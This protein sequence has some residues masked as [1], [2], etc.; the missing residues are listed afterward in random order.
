[1]DPE[2]VDDLLLIEPER[3]ADTGRS[4]HRAEDRGRMEAGF[5]HRFWYDDAQPAEYFGT[6]CDPAQ[7]RASVRAV[8]FAGGQHSRHDDGPGMHRS[9]L[10][11]VVEI[12]A[13]H[14]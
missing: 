8:P 12:L 14:G 2:R 13:M 4:P 5:M 1:C 6:D 10:K 11:G 3:R 7:R 9:A